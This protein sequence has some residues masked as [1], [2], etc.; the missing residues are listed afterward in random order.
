MTEEVSEGEGEHGELVEGA[1]GGGTAC[2][3]GIR[4]S[5]VKLN[6]G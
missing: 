6:S 4:T 5:D 2:V 3:V 1:L